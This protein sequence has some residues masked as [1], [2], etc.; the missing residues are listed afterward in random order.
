MGRLG[1]VKQISNLIPPS[2][3]MRLRPADGLVLSS[4]DSALC[5]RKRRFFA[6]VVDVVRVDTGC[7]EAAQAIVVVLLS[8]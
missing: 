1:K 5:R 6:A 2:T 4:G 8:E 7:L 3:A